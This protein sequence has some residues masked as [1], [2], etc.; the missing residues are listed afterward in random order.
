MIRTTRL[1]AAALLSSLLCTSAASGQT[2]DTGLIGAGGNIGVFFPDEAQEKAFTLEGQGEYYITPRVSVRGLLGWASPGFE[3]RTEDHFRQVRLL[4]NGVYN[5]EFGAIH[6]YAT[7]GVGAY[8]VRQTIEGEDDPDSET[9]GG[10][11]LGGGAEYFVS[12]VTS[13]KVEGRFDIVSHPP[14][15]PD[16]TGFTLT[17]GIKR[18]F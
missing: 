4:V 5:W 11:N 10:I 15:L 14:R 7:A 16:A 2:P 3:N 8:F 17:F 6:P 9:R 1:F 18:Y 13:L 12:D